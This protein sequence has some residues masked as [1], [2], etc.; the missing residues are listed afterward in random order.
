MAAALMAACLLLI[1]NPAYAGI[2]FTVNSTGD[3]G[4]FNLDDERC[5]TGARRFG[6][7]VCTLRAAIDSRPPLSLAIR[8]RSS[9]SKRKVL[10]GS[11][12]KVP[13]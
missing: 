11:I 12:S 1:A 10:I 7:E 6:A 3:E 9:R 13:V 4:D 2:T 5:F 8:A